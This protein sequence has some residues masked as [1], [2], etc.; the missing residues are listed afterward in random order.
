M[1]NEWRL[2]QRLRSIPQRL[3]YQLSIEA[4]S[5]WLTQQITLFYVDEGVFPDPAAQIF[6]ANPEATGWDIVIWTQANGSHWELLKR[7]ASS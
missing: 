6:L 5:D 7:S 2:R 4:F 3:I 1:D